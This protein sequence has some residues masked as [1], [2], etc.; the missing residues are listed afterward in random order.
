[1]LKGLELTPLN[2]KDLTTGTSSGGDG[3][4]SVDLSERRR[5]GESESSGFGDE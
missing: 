3:V 2:S 1:M 5:Y 4:G